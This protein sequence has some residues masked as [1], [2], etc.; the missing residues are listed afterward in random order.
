MDQE[1]GQITSIEPLDT[2]PELRLCGCFLHEALLRIRFSSD[3]AV[4]E[5]TIE[6]YRD[7]HASFGSWSFLCRYPKNDIEHLPKELFL[8]ADAGGDGT[9]PVPPSPYHFR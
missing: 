4:W 8:A 2:E 7:H 9:S 5:Q 6:M 3:I 1:S